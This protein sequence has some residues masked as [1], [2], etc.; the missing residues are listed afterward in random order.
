MNALLRK[1]EERLSKI[2]FKQKGIFVFLIFIIMT[3]F[4]YAQTC[5]G[6]WALTSN[7]SCVNVGSVTGSTLTRGNPAPVPTITYNASGAN[8]NSWNISSMN[9]QR[10]YQYRLTATANIKITNLSIILQASQINMHSA[11]RYSLDGFSTY[12]SL[13][14]DYTFT[15]SSPY[16]FTNSALSINMT[17][18]QTMTVRVYAWNASSSTS[19]FYNRTMTLSGTRQT[20]ASDYFRT[21]ANGNW[22]QTSTW[23]SS[24]DGST[25]INA[26]LIPASSANIVTIRNAVTLTSA[27]SC[28]NISFTTGSLNFG[29][30]NLT[31]FGILN[32]T[33]YFTYSGIGAPSQ[34]GI[35]AIVTVTTTTPSSLPMMMTSLTITTGVG[36]SMILPNSVTTTDLVFVNGSITLD[37]YDLI[38]TGSITGTALF[39]YN[40]DGGISGDGATNINAVLGI[41]SSDIIPTVVNSI[42]VNPGSGN[43]AILPNDVTTTT[44]DFTSGSLS[45]NGYDLTLLNKDFSITGSQTVADLKVILSNTAPIY[46]GI[47]GLAHTWQ[48]SG[49]VEGT[50]DITFSFPTILSSSPQLKVYY[51]KHIIGEGPWEYFGL[52]NVNNQGSYSYVIA[53]GV[54]FLS[55]P[56][57]DLD[58]T[59]AEVDQTLPV[60][61]TSFTASLSQQ[62]NVLLSW[63]AQTETNLLGYHVFRNTEN[64]I[65]TANCLTQELIPAS[66]T[67]EA[68]TYSYN[69]D[70]IGT[71]HVVYYYWIQYT[72]LSGLTSL[73]GP[74]SIEVNHT[75]IPITPKDTS[76]QAIYPNPFQIATQIKYGLHTDDRVTIDVYNIKGQRVNTLVSASKHAGSYE[77]LWNGHD[78]KGAKCASGIYYIM[79]NTG[80]IHTVRKVVKF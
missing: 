75:T 77:I 78:L 54:S 80:S 19:I 2:S 64:M 45:F 47:S 6:K 52:Y 79:M 17:N 46:N 5:S 21:K 58:W 39:F 14:A 71:E 53:Q 32:G 40:G 68:H 13:L 23:E 26:T 4:A 3:G 76:I 29:N 37:N 1:E 69:D 72:E 7:G 50:V 41:N 9:E 11:I 73:N 36:N 12:T 74:V 59:L 55:S 38:V 33:P 18:G 16:T 20:N 10:Y 49:T 63:V 60:E 28:G 57:G 22:N 24:L 61:L 43:Y 30:Y 66:N 51:R 34:T 27:A 65:N 35:G 42:N 67:S 56:E 31:I 48:T 25:W 70:E 44:L 15:S 62:T 8:S